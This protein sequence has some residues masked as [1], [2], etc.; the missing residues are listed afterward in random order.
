MGLIELA[1]NYGLDLASKEVEGALAK[2]G[3][4]WQKLPDN[5]DVEVSLDALKA[6][7]DT[8]P[9]FYGLFTRCV[10]EDKSFGAER[11]QQAARSLLEVAFG[12]PGLIHHCLLAVAFVGLKT[13]IPRSQ[14]QWLTM[15]LATSTAHQQFRNSGEVVAFVRIVLRSP[16]IAPK[17]RALL[18]GLLLS[19]EAVAPSWGPVLLRTVLE[20][21][22]VERKI[23]RNMCRRIV[24]NGEPLAGL[25]PALA[26]PSLKA[27]AAELGDDMEPEVLLAMSLMRQNRQE[28]LLLF[29]TRYFPASLCREAVVGLSQLG[30]D[31]ATLLRWAMSRTNVDADR[32]AYTAL[33]ALDVLEQESRKSAEVLVRQILQM[34]VAHPS[35]AVRQATMSLADRLG[36]RQVATALRR[37]AL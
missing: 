8:D 34:G 16:D 33:G 19:D 5:A 15:A 31:T 2:A 7:L 29:G 36:V 37:A 3:Q 17:D 1:E 27:L 22:R 18:V 21:G 24:E 32:S 25:R 30:D 20:S 35:D 14:G 4:Q 9:N 28:R 6:L 26:L 11:R 10:L 13:G 12:G 23:M